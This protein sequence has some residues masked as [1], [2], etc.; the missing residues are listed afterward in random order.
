[1]KNFILMLI[2]PAFL[3]S[4]CT[5]TQQMGAGGAALGAATG[6]IIGNQSGAGARDKGVLIGAIVG[7]LAGTA[8]G[9]KKE[10]DGTRSGGGSQQV[11][12]VCPSCNS[13][14]DVTGFPA[15]STVE[16][17]NCRSKFTY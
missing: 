8:L 13:K 4:G 11:V 6:A 1:M 9:Q 16:C 7:G 2:I 15:H 5:Q 14:V 10:I 3:Y 12:A 17:P